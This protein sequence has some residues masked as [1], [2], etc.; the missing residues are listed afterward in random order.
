MTHF[1]RLL[2]ACIL[3]LGTSVWG[4]TD[5]D[6]NKGAGPNIDAATPVSA[7]PPAA[8]S[9]ATPRTS[10]NELRELGALWTKSALKSP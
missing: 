5:P 9:Y 10:R 3:C 6:A 8:P 1:L 4:P 2:L 7:A